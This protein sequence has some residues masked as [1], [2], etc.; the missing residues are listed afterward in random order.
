MVL[1]RSISN[2]EF[3]TSQAYFSTLERL[4]G[5]VQEIRRDIEQILM[6]IFQKNSV[7][8]S[9]LHDCLLCLENAKWIDEFRSGV[10]SD[11]IKSVKDQIV[12]H[13]KAL[14]DSVVDLNLSLENFNKLEDA[15][16]AVL[17]IN[18][19]KILEKI[20]PEAG[21]HVDKVNAWFSDAINNVFASIENAFKVE[22]WKENGS[23]DLDLKKTEKALNY[24]AI[25]KTIK[26][27]DVKN[28]ASL[29]F[30]E[31]ENLIVQYR[32]LIQEDI[33]ESFKDI[34]TSDELFEN[35]LFA[36]TPDQPVS[37]A[38]TVG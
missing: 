28:K 4:C 9:K 6:L 26:L 13:V 29:L 2:I 37:E 31:L 32:F 14:H 7:S 10:Y 36:V 8:Y 17:D 20:I 18:D 5:F 11:I 38:A 35:K 3:R 22:K 12:Q 33:K 30:D 16:K 21:I 15:S 1:I 23:Q 19:I 25:C 34:I 27:F 24:L